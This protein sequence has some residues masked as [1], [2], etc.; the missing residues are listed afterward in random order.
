MLMVQVQRQHPVLGLHGPRPDL[1]IG[2]ELVISTRMT[3][4]REMS[5]HREYML[6]VLGYATHLVVHA[7]LLPGAI[8]G[9]EQ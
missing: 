1:L 2:S 4:P 3:H 7:V 9:A 8:L 5:S 6:T